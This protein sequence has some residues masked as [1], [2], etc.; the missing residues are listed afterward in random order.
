[1]PKTCSEKYYNFDKES[2]PLDLFI[3]IF[4]VVS[5]VAC[6]FTVVVRIR[7]THWMKWRKSKSYPN[8][9][10][11]E[12]RRFDGTS[13][14]RTQQISS[15]E[16]D[17]ERRICCLRESS[18]ILIFF[19]GFD[20]TVTWV[21]F[22]LSLYHAA[23]IFSLAFNYAELKPGDDPRYQ[24]D[25][26]S[27]KTNIH[28]WRDVE[29]ADLCQFQGALVAYCLP[30][31]VTF[32]G[33]ATYRTYLGF[34]SKRGSSWD[35][36]RG[37]CAGGS[38]DLDFEMRRVT[39]YYNAVMSLFTLVAVI[40]PFIDQNQNFPMRQQKSIPLCWFHRKWTQVL[41][42]VLPAT[43]GMFSLAFY[44]VLTIQLS[45]RYRAMMAVELSRHSS[46]GELMSPTQGVMN[47]N[48]AASLDRSSDLS[49]ERSSLRSEVQSLQRN[50][51][52]DSMKAIKKLRKG[53]FRVSMLM[54]I[55]EVMIVL[56]FTNSAYD[57]WSNSSSHLPCSF[58]DILAGVNA[59]YGLSYAYIFMPSDDLERA[60]QVIRECCGACVFSQG[61][62]RSS[63]RGSL[64]DSLLSDSHDDELSPPTNRSSEIRIL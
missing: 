49:L 9:H 7:F 6:L 29:A 46:E 32:G 56:Y 21:L 52:T 14:R 30:W 11:E 34:V 19:A 1:M 10:Q 39:F 5:I 51:S 27:D 53:A 58:L 63:V 13:A 38:E 57:Y 43:V 17:V 45:Q 12:S 42:A 36:I 4:N 37:Y 15:I 61:Q 50:T 8:A 24:D 41:F 33:L 59:I 55:V 18:S 16:V 47:R 25:Y 23:W 62:Q 2:S 48:V 60:L 40:A 3:N 35:G 26:T 54:I 20:G 44:G 64:N 28:G 31:M 22:I